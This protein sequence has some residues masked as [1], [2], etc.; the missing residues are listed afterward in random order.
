MTVV[1]DQEERKQT[2]CGKLI[3]GGKL[4]EASTA[5]RDANGHVKFHCDGRGNNERRHGRSGY[6]RVREGAN[7]DNSARKGEQERSTSGEGHCH[8]RASPSPSATTSLS[9]PISYLSAVRR[10]PTPCRP[11]DLQNQG[12]FPLPTTKPS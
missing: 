2:G 9:L 1:L 3:Q 5:Q 11:N 10:Q 8:L 7:E 4:R 12:H 6:S